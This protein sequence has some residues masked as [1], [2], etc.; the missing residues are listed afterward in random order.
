MLRLRLRS[1][2]TLLLRLVLAV[3][4]AV[5]HH[6]AAHKADRLRVVGPLAA[7]QAAA[8]P[9]L[10]LVVCKGGWD[11]RPRG[12][13]APAVARQ[14]KKRL[15]AIATRCPTAARAT[16]PAAASRLQRRLPI[17]T[18]NSNTNSRTRVVGKDAVQLV[19]LGL[20]PLLL[21]AAAQVEA[22]QGRAGRARDATPA[23][24]CSLPQA[25]RAGCRRRRSGVCPPAAL[26]GSP[27]LH[28][29][30]AAGQAQAAW[31]HLPQPARRCFNTKECV[32]KKKQASAPVEELA[33]DP[34]PS[35]IVGIHVKALIPLLIVVVQVRH[36]AA[37][38]GCL[39]CRRGE[40]RGA[41][42]AP[43]A[44]AAGGG[45]CGPGWGWLLGPARC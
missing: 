12:S 37:A 40:A 36:R 15:S 14:G 25:A 16:P 11:G 28:A 23:C 45:G 5:L 35:L 13:R 39:R 44:A 7:A 38:L 20:L 27:R 43:P 8:A 24:C 17:R 21:L 22:G 26:A 32:L 29:C 30:V 1:R 34:L 10:A 9:P 4:R 33:A 31:P 6:A 2:G 41:Q 42:A 3:L 18:Y 19:L